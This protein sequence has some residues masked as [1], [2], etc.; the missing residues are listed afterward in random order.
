M[1][2]SAYKRRVTFINVSPASI[3]LQPFALH[4]FALYLETPVTDFSESND[5]S[6]P[7]QLSTIEELSRIFAL[8]AD[9]PS[10]Q[11]EEIL[12]ELCADSDMRDRVRDLLDADASDDTLLDHSLCPKPPQ[13]HPGERIAGYELLQE[14]G[15]GGM[16]IVFKAE[17]TEPVHRT[18]ALKVIKPGID[19]REV[20]A[21]F[22]AERQAL[23]MMDHPNIA[24]VLD[25]G[26]TDTGRPFFVMEL[27]KGEPITQYCDKQRLSARQRLKLFVSVCQAIQHAH[28][29]GIIHRDIK[30]SNVLVAEYDGRP[31]AKVIDFGV[32]KAINQTLTEMNLHTGFGQI[33]GT[34]EYM[35][36]EQSRVEQVDVDTRSD[37]YSLGVLLY[38]LL[39]GSPPFSKERL[40]SVAWDEMMRIIKEEDPPKPSSRLSEWSKR[41]TVNNSAPPRTFLLGGSVE[42]KKN[43]SAKLGRLIRNELDWIV[44]KAMDKDRNRRYG[45]PNGLAND[46]ER[47]LSGEAVTACPPT[48]I[49]RFRKFA[50]R[51]KAVLATSAIVATSLVLGL[52][53]T[54]WQ[55][56]RAKRAEEVAATNAD[57]A[58]AV[59]SFLTDDLL[60]LAG[61]ESQLSAGL[62]PDPNLKLNTL[63]D[64][65]L[66]KTTE[67][68]AN[69]PQLKADLQA[70][71]ASSFSSI[72]RY[73]EASSL[74]QEML[75][76][77][78]LSKGPEHPETIRV[79]RQLARSYFDQ[80][81][82]DLAEPLYDVAFANSLKFLG[83]EHEMTLLLLN[84]L[85][86]LYQKQKKYERSEAA[87]NDCL[88]AR[89]RLLGDRHADT[90]GTMSNLATLYES[91]DRFD[92]AE[93]LH[94]KVLQT[95]RETLREQN[96]RIADALHNLGRCYL[97]RGRHD[98]DPT[99]FDRSLTLLSEGLEL[100]LQNPGMRGSDHPATLQVQRDLAQVYLEQRRFD[101][102]LPILNDLV[103][104]LRTLYSDQHIATIEVKSM[105]G[106]TYLH[107]E[108]L[109][110]AENTLKEIL[111]YPLLSDRRDPWVLRI[112]GNLA[113]VYYRLGKLDEA[114]AIDK[115]IAEVAEDVLGQ[116]NVETL[117]SLTRLGLCYLEMGRTIAGRSLL[118][119]VFEM[120]NNQPGA[121]NIAGELADSYASD[122]DIVNSRRWTHRQ[123]D[124][125]Q[126]NLAS[127]S[128]RLA[129]VMAECDSRMRR[130]EAEAT[131]KVSGEE[132]QYK[133]D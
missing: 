122:K 29:K 46:I 96:P 70:T 65:A 106:W 110:E 114:V 30:P 109:E 9:V 28:Q 90:L 64:R 18:V 61:A 40:R 53:G 49:Y 52:V 17:Q 123:V 7:N 92:E 94:K 48:S 88:K 67:R 105:L 25:A 60:G 62:R 132:S 32:A 44:M 82:L 34:Y 16:G 26:S 4:P 127:E 74:Y 13:I 124:N 81:K 41:K 130:I 59:N 5:E 98:E 36:P 121:F 38:E 57:E 2:A 115:Q 23:S 6:T 58:Q 14:L 54:T 112:M 97:N 43:E 72:G 50:N 108:R 8:V 126:S 75:E 80:S 118:E 12:E 131:D 76:Y 24:K 87:F 103:G 119:R 104:R 47:F 117:S 102:A 116:E 84:D 113:I 68:F 1:K 85:A 27:V 15:E 71:L 133:R 37:I 86:M 99:Q 22:N 3:R 89:K 69:Q 56:V 51:N 66:A 45:T 11:Q 101:L 39:T 128:S 20:I 73:E 63:L 100:N 77:L 91:L 111:N 79:T 78:A 129:S 10:S 83:K 93:E 31:I 19:T 42:R 95:R 107:L 125:A 35:S 55:A 21:R 120:G 33:I